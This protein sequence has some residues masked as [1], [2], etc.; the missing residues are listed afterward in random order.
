ML[1]LTTWHKSGSGW[2]DDVKGAFESFPFEAPFVP[3]M[4]TTRW[5]EWPDVNWVKKALTEQGLEDVTVG[6]HSHLQAVES[7]AEFVS[8]FASMV[9]WMVKT[10]WSDQ[11]QEEHSLDEVKKL[12]EEYLVEKHGGK[13]WYLTWTSITASG[14]KPL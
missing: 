5:G 8:Q 13:G 14:R 6:V 7:A 3:R 10:D 9:E 1:G 2:I 12:L 11:T 4:Q